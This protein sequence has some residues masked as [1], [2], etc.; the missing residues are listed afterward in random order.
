[1]MQWNAEGVFNKKLALT[2]KLHDLKIDIACIQETHLNQNN[3]FSI[4]GYQCFRLD[5]EARHKGGVLT[6]IKNNI[7]AT[8]IKI[9]TAQE[10]EII[11]C[12]IIWNGTTHTI[13]NY[14]CPPDKDLS[15]YRMDID[16][17]QCIVVGDFNAHSQSWGY[18][19]LDSRG[20]EV[21]D[22]HTIAG[23][24]L[25]NSPEDTA[26]FYSR[27]WMT[28]S[29]PDLAFCSNGIAGKANRIVQDQLAG[30]DHRPVVIEF[31]INSESYSSPLP[32]WNY[33][34]ADW[35]K[36]SKLCDQY[37]S[38]INC[39]TKKVN[40]SV[41]LFNKALIKAANKSIPRGSR[42]DYKPY[43]SDEISE[44]NEQVTQARETAEL[45]PSIENNISL[46]AKSAKLRK[47][48]L[49]AVRTSWHEKTS[50]LNLEKDGTKLWSLAKTLNSESN[51]S[52][53]IA[54][55]REGISSHKR[56]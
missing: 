39:K 29:T 23:L 35:T 8:E 52:A 4:R 51:Q 53:P 41:A 10:A 44:L 50:N 25:L 15:L 33:K 2:R 24:Q 11:G 7:A 56:K 20:E 30:S 48:T 42:K 47:E 17:E 27:R 5:R 13:Y 26:T 31:E 9:D 28:T 16:Q 22:W 21:E 32:R 55:E 38:S 37:T 1:M 40:K 19:S 6:L 54:I 45:Y 46:K 14:Y 18:D 34:K 36:F 12:K 3:R 43:W 49:A